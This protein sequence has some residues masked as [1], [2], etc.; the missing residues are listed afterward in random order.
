MQLDQQ[1]LATVP[2]PSKAGA[3][4]AHEAPS[5]AGAGPSEPTL[6][7]LRR[8]WA[9][10][11]APLQKLTLLATIADSS[12]GMRGGGLAG[13]VYLFSVNGDPFVASFAGR[14]V[15]RICQPLMEMIRCVPGS[16]LLS[17]HPWLTLCICASVHLCACR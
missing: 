8:L 6:L 4:S 11:Q 10:A 16:A 3:L 12:Q 2:S 14:V 7:S 15:Q 9:W 5:I 1:L 13:S 17:A